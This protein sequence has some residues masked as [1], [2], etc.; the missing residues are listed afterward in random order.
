MIAALD[1][2]IAA[3]STKFEIT[4]ALS[5]PKVRII[6]V[7][8]KSKEKDHSAENLIKE[9]HDVRKSLKT[10]LNKVNEYSPQRAR[11]ILSYLYPLEDKLELIPS[12]PKKSKNSDSIYARL[13]NE[14]DLLVTDFYDLIGLLEIKTLSPSLRDK[15]ENHDGKPTKG[16]K[17]F[18][19]KDYT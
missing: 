8:A 13:S 7:E 10:A 16:S 9:I 1:F 3:V 12:Y 18:N 4:Q 2:T 19:I 15:I 17:V 14:M 5:S 6:E 11:Q